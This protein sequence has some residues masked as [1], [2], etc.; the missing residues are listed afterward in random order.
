VSTKNQAVKFDSLPIRD[1]LISSVATVG[2]SEMTPVQAQCLPPILVGDDVIAQAKTGSGKTAAFALGILNRLV[3]TEYNTQALVLCPTRELAEQVAGSIR[4]LSAAMANTKLV[5]LCGGKP[6]Q[7]QLTSLRRSPHIVVG[8][9]GRVLNHLQK[10]SLD[11]SHVQSAVLDEADRMLDMGFQEDIQKIFSY[12][13]P[14]RQTLLFSATFPKSIRAISADV[15]TNPI[16]PRVDTASASNKIEQAVY[17]VPEEQKVATLIKLLQHHEPESCI[18]FCNQKVD[19]RAL[20]KELKQHGFYALELHGDLD[21]SQRDRALVQFANRSCSL[22][23]A[24]DVAARGLDI[25]ELSA[26]VNYD[27]TRDPEVHVHRIGRTGRAGKAGLALTLASLNESGRI[28]AVEQYQNS[29]AL[30]A[31]NGLNGD[32]IGKISI[33]DKTSFVAI[34]R[35]VAQLALDTI[36]S[37]KIKGRSFGAVLLR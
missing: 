13:K 32:Q 34:N 11:L 33:S 3:L 19:C 9:P 35:E 7:D 17:Q 2:Y 27:I 31:S 20:G 15:Q 21:Q 29:G 36:N 23:I 8:T 37:G 14:Q 5:T 22:L 24:T 1:E 16:E 30:T 28:K 18:I 12:V 10:S 4:Q 25:K 26:V 6:I